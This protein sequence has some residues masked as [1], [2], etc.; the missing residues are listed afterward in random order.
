[1]DATP[2]LLFGCTMSTTGGVLLDA[3]QS[4]VYLAWA[5][6]T[7]Q[8]GLCGQTFT[9]LEDLSCAADRPAA[10]GATAANGGSG[11]TDP[12]TDGACWY[13]VTIPESGGFLGLLV[14]R[15]SIGRPALTRDVTPILS[16]GGFPSRMTRPFRQVRVFG[17]AFATSKRSMIYGVDYLERAL[18]DEACAG[19]TAKGAVLQ[20]RLWCPE[21]NPDTD[22]R[23]SMFSAVLTSLTVLEE[24]VSQNEVCCD[25]KVPIELVFTVANPYMYGCALADSGVDTTDAATV[26]AS[27]STD[28]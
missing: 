22:G 25:Q 27:V 13:D 12:V 15:V 17:T 28:C 8:M 6:A 21:S 7:G 14:H 11:W 16:G 2:S 9:N 18:G 3:H 10:G 24:S 5:I 20:L 19:G 26:L 1:V 4:Y 23:V